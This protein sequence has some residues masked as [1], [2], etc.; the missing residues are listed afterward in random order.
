MN[1]LRLRYEIEN[2][3]TLIYASEILEILIDGFRN[4]ASTRPT[5]SFQIDVFNQFAIKVDSVSSDIV[6]DIIAGEFEDFSLSSSSD[7]VA[8]TNQELMV[9]FGM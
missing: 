7:V 9:E 3:S 1:D 8:A 5:Q 4:P 6:L 2:I